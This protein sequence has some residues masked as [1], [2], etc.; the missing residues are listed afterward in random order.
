M[1]TSTT[2]YF[3]RILQIHSFPLFVNQH[4]L[5]DR[6]TVR[7]K[8]LKFFHSPFQPA[9]VDNFIYILCLTVLMYKKYPT[10]VEINTETDAVMYN[11]IK[12]FRTLQSFYL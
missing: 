3:N 4:M 6:E 10:Y 9:Y 5:T 11:I 2:D 12:Y 8:C 7:H 1:N